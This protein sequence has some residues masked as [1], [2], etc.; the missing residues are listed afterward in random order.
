MLMEAENGRGFAVFPVRRKIRRWYQEA[1][2]S[3]PG[4]AMG[5]FLF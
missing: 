2:P 5:G 4:R 1:S 3:G